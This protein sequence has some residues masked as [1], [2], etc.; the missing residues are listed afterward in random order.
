MAHHSGHSSCAPN[1]RILSCAGG[2][3]CLAARYTP[4]IVPRPMSWIVFLAIALSLI[5]GVHFWI[6]S[7]LVRDMDLPLAWQRLLGALIGLLAISIPMTLYLSRAIDPV[8]GR[9]LLL[10]LYT[11]LGIVFWLVVLL[12]GS[13]LVR[14]AAWFWERGVREA[15]PAL[16]AERRTLLARALGSVVLL[17]TSGFTL[18]GLRSGLARVQVKRVE[19]KLAKLPKELDGFRIVQLT[20]VHVGPT[21]GRD[22]IEEI[23]ATCNALSADT[24]VITGDL[25]DGSVERLATAVAPLADLR[26]RHGTFFVTGNHEYYSGASAWCEK[27]TELGIRVLRNEHVSLAGSAGGTLDLAGV[28]D[29]HGG[30]TPGHGADL[31]AALRGRNSQHP[32]VLLAHQP[33]MIHQ[34]VAAGVDLQLSGHTHGGQLWPWQFFVRLQQ[35]VV[36][37]LEWFEKTAIYVSSGTGYWGPPLRLGAPAEIT[38]LVLRA[39]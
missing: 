30:R 4:E 28:D 31:S 11:W 21:I 10:V 16:A 14:V 8:R 27:L 12:A 35:P 34:A 15:A 38:E 36:A 25:V 20:D 9:P 1:T 24:V 17:V 37:G 33:K 29:L 26:S 22:F 3:R 39:G 5:G 7:R 23:V 13:E 2:G 19:I 6:W 32:L 18:S